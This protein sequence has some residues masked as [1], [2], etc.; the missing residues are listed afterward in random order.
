MI[1]FIEG[2]LVE[3][4]PT[5]VIVSCNGVGYH[6][7]ITLNTYSKLPQDEHI[8]LY[9]YLQIRED[10]HVLY[11]FIEK[12]ERDIFKLLLSVSGI[13]AATARNILSYVQP[14]DLMN[15]IANAEVTNLQKIKGIG[16]KAAQ[17]IVLDLQEKVIKIF[18]LKEMPISVNS[19]VSDEAV[20]ALEVL[21]FARVK[22]EKVVSQIIERNE[23]LSVEELIKEALKKL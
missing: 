17:R 9:T 2:R 5:E 20:T 6:I 14:N 1:S 8:K 22:A 23:D 16:P 7:N 4:T 19:T 11:G 21:G 12:T 18:A 10:A 15:A 13:G 3:K